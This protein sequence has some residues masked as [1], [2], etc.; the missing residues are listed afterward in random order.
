MRNSPGIELTLSFLAAVLGIRAVLGTW[1]V[2]F[3]YNWFI[4]VASEP[5]PFTSLALL[6]IVGSPRFPKDKSFLKIS[7]VGCWV[8]FL[9]VLCGVFTRPIGC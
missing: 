1:L 3:R 6:L 9:T 7:L 4:R 5:G 2:W 8:A